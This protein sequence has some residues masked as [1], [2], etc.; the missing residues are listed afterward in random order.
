MTTCMYIYIY[1]ISQFFLSVTIFV[2]GSFQKVKI[3]TRQNGKMV[4]WII[5]SVKEITKTK[6]KVKN[7][8]LGDEEEAE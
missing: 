2:F 5:L 7:E 3:L 8:K 1:I 6:E 4:K